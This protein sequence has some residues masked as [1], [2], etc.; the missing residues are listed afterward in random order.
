MW[1][2]LIKI[3]VYDYKKI[4][5]HAHFPRAKNVLTMSIEN[6]QSMITEKYVH[7]HILPGLGCIGNVN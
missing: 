3:S 2:T 7:M 1:I 6:F 5:P 4:C